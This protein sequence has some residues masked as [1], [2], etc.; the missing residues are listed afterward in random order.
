MTLKELYEEGKNTLYEIVSNYLY[1]S[2]EY[3]AKYTFEDYLEEL[4][5]CPRCGE[6]NER[7]KMVYHKWDTG[8]IEELICESC[9]NDE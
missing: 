6:I 7:D 4:E 2:A 5:K 8:N 1:K 3:R 9:R